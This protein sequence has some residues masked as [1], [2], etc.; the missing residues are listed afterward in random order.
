M[1]AW[2]W[3]SLVIGLVLVGL[4]GL[5]IYDLTQKRHAI[6]RN[7]PIIGHLRFI[8]ERFGPELRQYIVTNNDEERPFN[9]DQRRWVYASAKQENAYFGFGSDSNFDADGYVFVRHST[10][11]AP[12]ETNA[13]V[14]AA[15]VIGAWSE[16]PGAFRPASV[17]NISAMSFGSLSGPAIEAL[18]RGAALVGCLHNTGEGGISSHHRLGGDLIFQI[19][20]GYFGARNDAGE[21]CIDALVASMAGAPVRA[22]EIKLSQG[23]KPGLGGVLPGEKVTVEI[24]KARGVPVGKSVVSPSAHT[25][26][27]DV[28]SMVDVVEAIASATGVP[29]GIKSAVGQVEF[30]SE[31]AAHMAHT[32]R[33]PDFITVDGGEGGTGAAP[34]VFADHVSVPFKRG[35]PTVMSAFVREG[36][37]LDVAFFGAGKLGFA[38]DA[39]TAMAMG[40]DVINVGREAMLAIGCIQAQKCHTGHCPTGVATQQ[41]RLARGLDPTDKSVRLANYVMALNHELVKVAA[42]TGATHP[43]LIDPRHI[44]IRGRDGDLYPVLDH[45]GLDAAAFGA[46]RR[47]RLQA[48]LLAAQ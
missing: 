24:S 15:K 17:T 29:V 46:E 23:A 4:I 16:R 19:G 5:T 36:L 20:T 2:T 28:A 26:F 10:F 35:F 37:H 47:Q 34:L 40:V 38:A 42:A 8:L 32:G 27:H 22:I 25:A 3:L 30:W 21:F 44:E 14:P 33:G 9:R 7:Y 6:L 41:P 39:V 11:P 48:T 1:N 18:N 31:L 13:A 45:Y 43:A 12:I